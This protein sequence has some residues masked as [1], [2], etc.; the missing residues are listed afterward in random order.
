[1]F[2]V[3]FF[4]NP[5]GIYC[6]D[7]EKMV[8]QT[9]ADLNLDVTYHYLPLAN[10]KIAEKDIIRRR[11]AKQN[12]A[13]FSRYTIALHCALEFYH[14]IKLAYGNKKAR[15]FLFQLQQKLS[16][17]ETLFSRALLLRLC[18]QHGL[19]RQVLLSLL[20]SNYVINSI[21]QDQKLA[22]KWQI[23]QTPTIIIYNENKVQD[24]GLMLEGLIDQE[25]LHD[26]FVSQTAN[27]N[28]M[29]LF[30]CNNNYLR[31]I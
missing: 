13:N 23:K 15:L 22:G 30:T 26:L 16:Q 2:E 17:N 21:E 10:M 24:C 11:Q 27:L 9:A 14:A 12:L 6:Y 25:K 8:H 7:I 20:S 18:Q 5:I 29:Q 1:M 31:L 28:K 3:F 4:I 19:N